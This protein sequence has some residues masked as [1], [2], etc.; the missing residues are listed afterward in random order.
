MVTWVSDTSPFEVGLSVAEV[1]SFGVSLSLSSLSTVEKSVRAKVWY[2]HHPELWVQLCPSCAQ[3]VW[4]ETRTP[5][6]CVSLITC[7]EGPAVNY[8]VKLL[9]A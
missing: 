3:I 9:W 5:R 4:K 7:K 8:V 6:L 2:L 1:F